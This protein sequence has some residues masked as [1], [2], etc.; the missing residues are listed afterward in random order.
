[1]Q[2]KAPLRFVLIDGLPVLGAHADRQAVAAL[3]GV[4]DEHADRA[5]V[6][7]DL[8]EG[9]LHGVGVADVGLHVAARATER[10]DLVAVVGEPGGDRGAD[11]ARA[12]G[13]RGR[14]RSQAVA[15]AC[16]FQDM[17]PAPHA[18]PAPNVAIAMTSPGFS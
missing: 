14:R 13:R 9:G 1:M 4:V 2:W 10:D 15:R 11:A 7:A 6:G 17:T 5:V 16:S 3:A 18:K 12:S 8:V